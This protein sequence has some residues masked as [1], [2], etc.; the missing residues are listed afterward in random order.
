M[1]Y[2]H[3][4]EGNQLGPTLS[5]RGIDNAAY[6]RLDARG[7]AL[8]LRLHRHRQQP[9]HAASAHDPADHGQ[10]ALLGGRH[11]R[12]RLPLRPRAG[13][14]ARAVRGRP[15]GAFFDII[16]Q[17]PVLSKVKLI[18]EPWDVGPGGYQVGNFP[19]RL[20]GV[21]R[22]VP[23]LRAR[24]SGAASR[25]R[26]AEIASRLVGLERHLPAE[27]PRARTR[28]STSSPRTTATRCTTSCQLRAE[29]QRGQRR[30]QPRR[31]TTTTSAA[32]GASRARRTT[33]VRARRCAAA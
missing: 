25:G 21:E 4:G 17:D 24:S 12:R 31:H 8:L 22:Q 9:Q 10:P 3:T 1:V 6:Y 16:Q 32:T 5:L 29:A 11:A 14:G 30:G 13:A 18:A 15:A 33:R 19:V 23:R 28:A 26:L 27:R 20:G 2:N 7:P